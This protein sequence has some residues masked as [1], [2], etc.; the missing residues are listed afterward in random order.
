METTHV[1][2][3]LLTRVHGLDCSSHL[4]PCHQRQCRKNRNFD[5]T[6]NLGEFSYRMRDGSSLT[7]SLGVCFRQIVLQTSCDAAIRA[8][9]ILCYTFNVS[10]LWGRAS[11]SRWFI[12][13]S[14]NR[15]SGALPGHS[16]G[17]HLDRW[18][19]ASSG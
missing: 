2:G 6:D 16:H 5:D 11:C 1:V 13:T 9:S 17:T 12:L 10:P 14:F 8:D 19:A 15:I 18:N 7:M 4:Q 3:I